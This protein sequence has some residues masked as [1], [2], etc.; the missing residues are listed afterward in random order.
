MCLNGYS[1]TIIC[2]ADDLCSTNIDECASSPCVHGSCEDGVNSYSCSCLPG[3]TGTLCEMEID[4]CAVYDPCKN[5][6]VC[7]DLVA[8]YEC[9]CVMDMTGPLYGGQNCT[10]ELTGCQSNQ[11]QNEALC[12][13]VLLNEADN[14]HN[15]SCQ[16]Q[17]GY[18]GV[19]CDIVTTL[20]MAGSS[21]LYYNKLSGS[22]LHDLDLMLSFRTTLPND[23]LV[24]LLG[25]TAGDYLMVMLLDAYSIA[26]QIHT[27]AA[28]G[29]TILEQPA[30]RFNDAIW[31]RVTINSTAE[32]TI[33]ASVTHNP[34][35]T[36][37]VISRTFQISSFVIQD[38]YFGG[39]P[40]SLPSLGVDL[41][42]PGFTGCMQDIQIGA[43]VITPAAY[44]D[45]SAD[46]MTG[47]PRVDQCL[48]DPCFGHGTC[49]DL[50]NTFS[51]QCRRPWFGTNCNESKWTELFP[52]FIN[53]CLVA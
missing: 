4:E 18:T 6:A 48:P 32:N 24:L 17:P 51:C 9:T 41:D 16:C 37:T 47:C 19:Y 11:C 49:R 10:V 29:V 33:E 53:S 25:E 28:S 40:S 36:P 45:Q 15:Y 13:P 30:L 46:V 31:H 52:A 1:L 22:S 26:V 35:G 38:I 12:I 42:M 23:V 50:W 3:Y 21:W 34:Q 2:F 5:G 14:I 20:S 44:T 7:H 43:D 8:A 27:S 39:T